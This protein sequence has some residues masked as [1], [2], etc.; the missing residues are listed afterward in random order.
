MRVLVTGGAGYIGSILTELLLQRGYNVT[1]LDRFFF[2]EEAIARMISNPRLKAIKDD[3]RRFD[4]DI[5]SGIDTV[6]DLASL[7]NDPAGELDPSKT[8][9][10]NYEGR[11]RVATL[12]KK[13]G[14]KRYILPSSCSVYGFQTRILD[15]ESPT[16][17]LTTYAKANLMA[18][19]AILP[20]ANSKFC[21]TAARQATVYGLSP[22]MRFD[23]A[24]NEM[25]LGVYKNK[26][27]RVMNDGTQWRPFVH[28]KDNSKA[29][30][31]IMETD[32]EKVNDQRFNVG[33]NNQNYQ[34]KSLA[35][36]V[37]NELSVKEIEW[38][39]N[40]DNRSY[41]VNFDKIHRQLGY[42]AE[43]TPAEGAREI[44]EALQN[45]AVSDSLK[46]NTVEWYKNLMK[47]I[48]I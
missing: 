45:G 15:E 48:Q 6:I 22:R 23:L 24:I 44:Y 27:L 13:H 46:T 33:S 12:S 1:I 42:R 28:V 26:K 4:P 47:Q 32:I 2:G 43:Y 35:K 34:I 5:L 18:E 25:A 30:I 39:G 16:N 36:I 11:A 31:T 14:V 20:L 7:S 19:K 10:I 8:L 38:Y 21:V 41:R 29:L 40:H 17:P 37:Q 9:S 3:I